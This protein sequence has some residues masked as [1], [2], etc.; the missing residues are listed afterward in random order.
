MVGMNRAA[1]IAQIGAMTT[2]KITEGRSIDV[3]GAVRGFLDAYNQGRNMAEKKDLLNKKQAY[4]DALSG[5]DQD[6]IN[7]AWAAY[8]P[9]SYAS[10]MQ[11]QAKRAED[12]QWKLDD[13]ATAQDFQR[14][15]AQLKFAQDMKLEG[16]KNANAWG[17]KRWDLEN[18]LAQKEMERQQALEDAAAQREFQKELAE[19]KFK[20][21][22]DLEGIKSENKR[23]LKEFELTGGMGTTAQQNVK[24]MIDA[25]YSPQEA[26][27]MYYGGNNPTLDMAN[28]GKK[29][30]EAYDKK[31]GENLGD[32][33]VAQKQMQT[34]KPK[35]ENAIRRAKESLAEGTGL[36]QF[37]GWGWTT[38][39]GGVNRANIKNAQAQI[40]TTMR[41]LLKQLGVGS[42]ELNSAVEAEAYRYMLSPDMPIGQQLQVLKNF[43]EDYLSGALAKDLADTYGKKPSL[44][45]FVV[46][47]DVNDPRVQEALQNGY[48]M[49][50]IQAY[51]R[52]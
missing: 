27:A 32:E 23:S 30:M 51:L 3:A 18:T 49:E 6:Q 48:S 21:D 22:S 37:G 36:G 12:R 34:L 50:E 44:K 28:L 4:I 40:N 26:W 20:Q 38:E 15:L 42:T 14:E 19:L 2:P 47:V 16:A 10:F 45:D 33:A 5:G 31:I 46:S 17:L 24:A 41:G 52:K 35:A 29:G 43:E 1:T 13:L 11:N 8:D 39:Q 7:K 25:G 9:Q